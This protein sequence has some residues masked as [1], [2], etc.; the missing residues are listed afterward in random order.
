MDST[1]GSLTALSHTRCMRHDHAAHLNLP[2][3]PTHLCM[4][5]SLAGVVILQCYQCESRV[6][7]QSLLSNEIDTSKEEKSSWDARLLVVHYRS[8]EMPWSTCRQ[9]E[10]MHT[11][12]WNMHDD[13]C[14]DGGAL[15][16]RVHPAPPLKRPP[17]RLQRRKWRTFCGSQVSGAHDDAVFSLYQPAWTDKPS[18]CYAQCCRSARSGPSVVRARVVLHMWHACMSLAL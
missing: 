16:S 18:S 1:L 6:C 17:P 7:L 9:T 14:H 15:Q 2:A 13:C 5:M 4:G 11:A 12:Y 3:A 10:H 8:L